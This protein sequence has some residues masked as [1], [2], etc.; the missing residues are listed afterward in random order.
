MNPEISPPV[1]A[2]L[3]TFTE[4]EIRDLSKLARPGKADYSL[5]SLMVSLLHA[6]FRLVFSF[7]AVSDPAK[8]QS[9][10]AWM[11]SLWVYHDRIP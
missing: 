4:P 8:I 10:P 2:T 7:T 5:G 9:S 1:V 3:G 6:G 11:D